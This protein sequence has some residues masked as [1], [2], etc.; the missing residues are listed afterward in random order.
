MDSNNHNA[1][2]RMKHISARAVT[3]SLILLASLFWQG[4]MVSYKFNGAAIDYN[5]Y[6]TISIGQFPIRAALV[7]PP[8]Q[9]TF[10]NELR[11]L[12]ELVNGNIYCFELMGGE[13]LLHPQL[14]DFIEIT[15]Q[16]VS[17]IKHLCTNGVL[18]PKQINENK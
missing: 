14:E 13:A 9:Q 3:L 10:E 18:L 4:C 16:Y 12:N 5:V 8:L 11:R 1:V 17:G 7:Y 2:H 15:A 6:K